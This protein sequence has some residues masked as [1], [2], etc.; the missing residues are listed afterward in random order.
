M[1]SYQFFLKHAGYSYDP[2]TQTPMQGRIQTARRLAKAERQARDAGISFCWG[3]DDYLSSEWIADNEDG[4]RNRDPWRT[5]Y[6]TA[7]AAPKQNE[8][9]Y[10]VRPNVLASLSGI[11]FGR[12]GEPWGAPYRRVVEAELAI[13]ALGNL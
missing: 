6:C 3:Q 10:G 8:G 4:G 2:K 7:Y 12:D 11:D 9:Y 13:E 5:W 1:N